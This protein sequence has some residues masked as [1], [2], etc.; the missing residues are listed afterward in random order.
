MALSYI[1][2]SKQWRSWWP[3][4]LYTASL[5]LPLYTCINLTPLVIEHKSYTAGLSNM[6]VIP[7]TLL[8][9]KT[10]GKALTH[11]WDFIIISIYD[12]FQKW[13][14]LWFLR[15]SWL[16][17][18]IRQKSLHSA[19]IPTRKEV[20]KLWSSWSYKQVLTA[21]FCRSSLT[22]C[23]SLVLGCISTM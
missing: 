21:V 12:T 22:S 8:R 9:E 16:A 18:C 19:R 15:R 4:K 13:L 7:G 5:F 11:R 1:W 17:L 23:M 10:V 6:N 3:Q 20:S 14:C 2:S